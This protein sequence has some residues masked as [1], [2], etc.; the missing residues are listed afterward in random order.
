MDHRAGATTSTHVVSSDSASRRARENAALVDRIQLRRTV[1]PA[2]ASDLANSRRE[3]QRPHRE[4]ARL[5]HRLT[6]SPV[7]SSRRR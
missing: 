3:I 7:D 5:K 2:M 6:R 1:L 4:D